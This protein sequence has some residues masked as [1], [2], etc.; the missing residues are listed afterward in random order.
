MHCLLLALNALAA[1]AVVDTVPLTSPLSH[2]RALDGDVASALAAGVQRSP[3]FARLVAAIN[4]S[5]VIVYVETVHTLPPATSGRMVLTTKNTSVRYVRIQIASRLF[6][7]ERIAVIG[8]ELQHAVL[9]ACLHAGAAA[10]AT[11]EVD[12]RQLQRRRS[13]LPACGFATLFDRG[14]LAPQIDAAMPRRGESQRQDHRERAQQ[15]PGHACPPGAAAD[16]VR[17]AVSATLAQRARPDGAAG[18]AA[19]ST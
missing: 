13:G 2:V 8:H 1:C 17:G 12:H 11:R 10:Q 16:P 6:P 4:Q 5:D 3:T 15:H 18:S 19:L 9:G 14:R 7:D